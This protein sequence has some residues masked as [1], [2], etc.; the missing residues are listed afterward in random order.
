MWS[1]GGVCGVGVACAVCLECVV[2][3]CGVYV[4]GVLCACTRV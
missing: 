2:C 3:V 1:L 4:V